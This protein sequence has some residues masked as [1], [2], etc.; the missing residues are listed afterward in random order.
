MTCTKKALRVV[1][2]AEYHRPYSGLCY[3]EFGGRV[4]KTGSAYIYT[5]VCIGEFIAFIIGWNLILEYL[6]GNVSY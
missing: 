2:V 5:Y 4:P 1:Q 3:A 6:I